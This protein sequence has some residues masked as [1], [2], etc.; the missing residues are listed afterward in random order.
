MMEE[1]LGGDVEA[2]MEDPDEP[3]LV[4]PEEREQFYQEVCLAI[5]LRTLNI[6]KVVSWSKHAKP[7]ARGQ[8]RR[9]RWTTLSSPNAW[10]KQSRWW[11]H[12]YTCAL[13]LRDTGENGR[14]ILTSGKLYVHVSLHLIAKITSHKPCTDPLQDSRNQTSRP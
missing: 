2:E 4:T 12:V 7:S 5:A 6:S 8:L 13:D 3:E 1:Q 11:E 10:T 9:A 14:T